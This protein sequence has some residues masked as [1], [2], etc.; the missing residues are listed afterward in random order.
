M[1]TRRNQL[2]DHL[3]IEEHPKHPKPPH[4]TYA[5]LRDVPNGTRWDMLSGTAHIED[6]VLVLD[7]ES[8][9]VHTRRFEEEEA[10]A[11]V[12]DVAELDVLDE[13]AS[14]GWASEPTH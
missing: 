12:A 8:P 3:M 4:L 1:C 11:F 9:G 10:D 2:T 5:S 13:P 14:W 6:G 7:D